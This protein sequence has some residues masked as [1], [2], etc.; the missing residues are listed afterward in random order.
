MGHRMA[1]KSVYWPDITGAEDVPLEFDFTND[2]NAIDSTF[3]VST[4]VVTKTTP[5][6]V[7]TTPTGTVSGK[8]VTLWTGALTTAG[9]YQYKCVATLND[10]NTTILE[11]NGFLRVTTAASLAANALIALDDFKD[12]MGISGGTNDHILIP[13]ITRA[14]QYIESYCGRKF[15]YDGTTYGVYTSSTTP[16]DSIYDGA[17]SNVIVLRQRPVV[18]ITQIQSLISIADGSD[19]LDSVDLD[20]A[21]IDKGSGRLTL[22]G[23]I[24]EKGEQNVYVDYKAGYSTIPADLQQACMELTKTW[25]MNRQMNDMLIEER[26]DKYWYRKPMA[27]KTPHFVK[28]IL[29]LYKNRNV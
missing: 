5:A 4:A 28:E 18:S 7:V 9:V 10:T 12:Y 29:N 21:R 2:V 15:Y 14:T 25:W 19:Y 11:L 27:A 20:D 8:K 6:G 17:G 16:R 1:V 13:L 23:Y 3:A 26:L 24:F 22:T